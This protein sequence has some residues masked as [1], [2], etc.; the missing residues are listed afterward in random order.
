MEK[1]DN[2]ATVLWK[3]DNGEKQEKKFDHWVKAVLFIEMLCKHH[4]K[5]QDL[6]GLAIT[7]HTW[8][9]FGRVTH[10]AGGDPNAVQETITTWEVWPLGWE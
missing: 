5:K 1:K 9:H 8:G 2:S 10:V 3:V 6:V 7:G 4:E